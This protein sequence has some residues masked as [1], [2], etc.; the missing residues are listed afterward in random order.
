MPAPSVKSVS[1]AQPIPELLVRHLG[2]IAYDPVWRDMQRFTAERDANTASRAAF[3]VPFFNAVVNNTYGPARVEDCF[4]R[5]VVV[6]NSGLNGFVDS[7]AYSNLQG[8]GI[9][10]Q[11]ITDCAGC[12][13]A[14]GSRRVS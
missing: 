4:L 9:F 3:A 6:T 11:S 7:L 1:H 5:E 10:V 14:E 8:K 12:Y 2:S 13:D